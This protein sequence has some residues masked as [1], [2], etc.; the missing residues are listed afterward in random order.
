MAEDAENLRAELAAASTIGVIGGG[1]IGLE[2]AATFAGLGKDVTVFEAGERL[3]GRAVSP[4]ISE[5]FLH[6]HRSNGMQIKLN[7]SVQ[8]VAGQSGKAT[9]VICNDEEVSSDVVLIGIG[10]VANSKIAENAGLACDN[11]ILVD[12][13][14]QTSDADVL[15][16]GDCVSFEHWQTGSRVRLESVQNAN[17]Q[18]RNAALTL[19]GN[20]QEYREVPWFWS[21]QGIDKLQIVGLSNGSDHRIVREEPGA[22]KVSVYH[23]KSS[24]LVAIDTINNPAEHMIGRRILA[25]SITPSVSDFDASEFNLRS[26]LKLSE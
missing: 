5:Y 21:D 3:L 20:K 17:D 7:A 4:E 1:F 18:A 6:K 10:V 24:R 2:A 9:G 25:G 8:E 15:A 14:M 13:H 19:V 23:F 11:G 26:Y 22:N 12:A 16:I